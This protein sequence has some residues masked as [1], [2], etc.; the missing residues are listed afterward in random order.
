M[1]VKVSCEC[2]SCVEIKPTTVGNVA[3]FRREH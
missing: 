3:W 1:V 2:G